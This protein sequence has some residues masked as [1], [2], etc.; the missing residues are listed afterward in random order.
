MTWFISPAISAQ[1]RLWKGWT[2]EQAERGR[3]R[4]RR[5]RSI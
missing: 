5:R 4:C 1:A 2:Q 3:I